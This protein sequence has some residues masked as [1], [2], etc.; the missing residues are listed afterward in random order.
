MLLCSRDGRPYRGETAPASCSTHNSNKRNATYLNRKNVHQV[1]ARISYTNHSLST[2]N[3]IPGVRKRQNERERS[4]D[5]NALNS[6]TPGWET[7]AYN[8]ILCVMFWT[9]YVQLDHTTP[10]TIISRL[11]ILFQSTKCW[12]CCSF[13]MELRYTTV[14]GTEKE[15]CQRMN[16]VD[17]EKWWKYRHPRLT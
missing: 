4:A 16:F 2:D 15:K 1:N 8:S 17:N 5:Q 13:G 14:R 3:D 9:Y 12:I 7:L 11:R 6:R 10:L